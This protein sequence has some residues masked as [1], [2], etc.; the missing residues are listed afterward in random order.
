MIWG[1]IKVI[2]GD[3]PNWFTTTGAIFEILLYI[4]FHSLVGWLIEKTPLKTKR[5]K[6]RIEHIKDEKTINNNKEVK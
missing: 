6:E 3:D 4:S 2:G 1:S 5:L